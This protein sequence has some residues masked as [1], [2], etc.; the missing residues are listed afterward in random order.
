MADAVVSKCRCRTAA[1]AAR[2]HRQPH[3]SRLPLALGASPLTDATMI[4]DTD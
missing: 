1:A 4:D 2:S 3:P